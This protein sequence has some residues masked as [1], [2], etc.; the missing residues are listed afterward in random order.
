[1]WKSEY[2]P[3]SFR[4][5]GL[6][7]VSL[8]AWRWPAEN[9]RAIVQIAHGMGEHALRYGPLAARLNAAG[10][11][12]YSHD[13][14]GHGATAPDAA[15][16]GDFGPG[17]FEAVVS[18]LGVIAAL[19]REENPG[20]PLVLL[21]HSMGS[22]A[23]QYFALDRSGEI[24]A[25]V[26]SGS[27][28][29]DRFAAAMADPKTASLDT[30]GDGSGRTPFD[31]L[32]RDDSEVDKYIADPLCGF[33]ARPEGIAGMFAFAG[34]AASPSGVRPDLPVL[35][36]AGDQDPLNGRLQLLELLAS[37]YREA[38][39]RDV[40]TQFYPGGR[41]EMFNETNRAEVIDNLVAWLGR[42][43]RA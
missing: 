24:D 12:V 32:S 10:Y 33:T 9:P 21:G 35:L 37:R 38:G 18:D 28:A 22:F 16:L 27:T 19:A 2:P 5:R 17:G 6:D 13:H 3:E 20:I 34:R 11:A 43:T 23:A 41:H 39:V 15:A 14:R 8:A 36:L 29:V 7:G 31:W 1:M 40:E 26:L 30:L 42:V 4:L 25:L